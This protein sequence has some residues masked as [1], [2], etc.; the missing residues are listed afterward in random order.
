MQRSLSSLVAKLRVA[1]H[2]DIGHITFSAVLQSYLCLLQASNAGLSVELVDSSK[3]WFDDLCLSSVF[4][5]K[6][7]EVDI[8]RKEFSG[9]APT[10]ALAWQ[11]VPRTRPVS[12]PTIVA[13]TSLFVDRQGVR[14]EALN[15]LENIL[16]HIRTALPQNN[17]NE[18]PLRHLVVPFTV[19]QEIRAMAFQG[20][21]V[22]NVQQ[23]SSMASCLQK[24]RQVL[25]LQS[26]AL[27]MGKPLRTVVSVI[28]PSVEL[29]HLLK[30][31]A[32]FKNRENVYP[33]LAVMCEAPLIRTAVLAMQLGQLLSSETGVVAV[34]S[35][36]ERR[37]VAAVGAA[38][39]ASK[40]LDEVLLRTMNGNSH[41]LLREQCSS[42]ARKLNIREQNLRHSM[43]VL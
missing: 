33:P 39:A 6:W 10:L 30:M 15:G 23:S 19:L 34:E 4:S 2:R 26:Q 32:S 21:S 36:E 37:Q 8:D 16:S 22:A 3:C 7:N 27:V 41:K 29:D 11:T 13:S 9:P 24:V 25:T 20:K 1:P 5:S 17:E 12:S 14:S 31:H 42:V 38:V 35:V 18:L 40:D 43:S 28:P